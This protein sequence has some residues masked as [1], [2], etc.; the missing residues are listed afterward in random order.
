MNN[1]HRHHYRHTGFPFGTF[2][3]GFILLMFFGW[4]IFLIVP[5]LMM[6][7]FW[8]S[9]GR[10]WQYDRHEIDREKLKRKSKSDDYYNTEYV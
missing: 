2:L 9:W 3:F 6:F 10:S 1:Y 8:G 7:G 5:L 4:K